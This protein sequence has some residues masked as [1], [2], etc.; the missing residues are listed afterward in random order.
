MNHLMLKDVSKC[1][2]SNEVM[3]GMNFS[4]K[5]DEFVSIIGPSGSGKSTIFNL[6]GGMLSPDTGQILLE[7]DVINGKR[8]FIS[9]MPQTPSLLPWRT[10]LDNVL[11]GAEL[12]GK[13]ETGKAREML[14]IAGLAG[15]EK[16]FPHELSGG[17]KQRVAFIRA[18]LS[19]QA[20]ICLDEPFSALDELTRLEMQKW[21]ISVW[22][23]HK[24]TVLFITHNIEEALYL[25]DRI[26]VLS[27]KPSMVMSEIEVPF[28]RPREAG[29]LLEDKF[30]Q[31]KRKVHYTLTGQG[32]TR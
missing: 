6:I 13:K 9:Y 26:L 7:N 10:I 17:M 19:P 2:G 16:A 5:K 22:E 20:V 28:S 23:T 24:R 12:K 14:E 32:K 1:F 29:I 4:I 27:Q 3:T 25:S 30:L 8:G 15:Y 11:L 18:L 31:W 21:L